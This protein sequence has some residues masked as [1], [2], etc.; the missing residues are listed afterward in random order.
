MSKI[1]INGPKT[2]E[3]LPL[4]LEGYLYGVGEVCHNLFGAKGE[5]A[6]YNAIGSFFIK[7]IKEKQNVEIISDDPWKR[8]CQLVEIFTN[9][10]FYEHVELED[11]SDGKF[12]MLETN[13]YAG[14]IWEEQ[15]SWIRGSAPCPLWSLILACLSEINYSIIL[16][17]VKYVE[18]VNGFESTFHFEKV[19]V[20]EGYII[21]TTKQKILNSILTTCCVCNKFKNSKGEWVNVD[22][23]MQTDLNKSLSH[24][25]CPECHDKINEETERHLADYK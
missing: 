14:K 6:M 8:Y 9:H 23:F 15:G 10:G 1:I 12:W 2:K 4:L 7:Y 17:E 5:E 22:E 20:D 16:D 25:Y 3:K 24:G 13:Q 18:S 19:K 21:D 11:L